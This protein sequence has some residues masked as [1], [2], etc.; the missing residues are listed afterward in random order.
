MVQN[1]GS[2]SWS[3]QPLTGFRRHHGLARSGDLLACRGHFA[4]IDIQR[5]QQ[6]DGVLTSPPLAAYVGHSAIKAGL[7]SRI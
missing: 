6:P 3:R 7:A 4:V 2:K 1:A 5:R